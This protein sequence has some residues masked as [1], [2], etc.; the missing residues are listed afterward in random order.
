M[1]DV[2]NGFELHALCWL[3]F[4]YQF[5]LRQEERDEIAVLYGDLT[6]ATTEEALRRPFTER[7]LRPRGYVY[8]QETTLVAG[9]MLRRLEEMRPDY[10][11]RH[12][13]RARWISWLNTMLLWLLATISLSYALPDS[14][15]YR[16]GILFFCFLAFLI[17]IIPLTSIVRVWRLL[18][19]LVPKDQ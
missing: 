12:A 2:M 3:I 15:F 18:R 4:I 16:S 11:G 9:R 7:M 1:G 14:F 13:L 6:T 8:S 19:R 10:F 5:R 17:S